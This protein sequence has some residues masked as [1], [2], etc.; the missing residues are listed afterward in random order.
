MR[1]LAYR[2][3]LPVL[4]LGSLLGNQTWYPGFPRAGLALFYVSLVLATYVLLRVFGRQAWPYALLGVIVLSRIASA[5]E[6]PGARF[7]Y[8]ASMNALFVVYG[9]LLAADAP[10]MLQRQ[11]RIFV[12]ASVPLLALQLMG[13]AEWLH[14]FNTLYSVSDAYGN[15]YRP[16]IR[17]LPTLFMTHEELMSTARSDYYEFFAWQVRPSG[18]AHSSAMLG[19]LILGAA[20]LHFGRMSA[21]RVTWHDAIFVSA[22]VLCCSKLA[23]LGFVL[24]M[25]WSYVRFDPVMRPRIGG[26][27]AMF[28][29]S[30]LV[31]GAMFPAVFDH[32][33]GAGA[34]E[35]S[36]LL[37]AVDAFLRI[38]PD[39][40]L[41]MPAVVDVIRAYD[42][43]FDYRGGDAG[44]L[45]GI[46]TLVFAFPLI[47]IGALAGLPWII[48]GLRFCGTVYPATARTAELMMIVAFVIPIAT[49]IFVSQFFALFIGLAL[50]PLASS[51][52]PALR[53]RLLRSAVRAANGK[54]AA[55]PALPVPA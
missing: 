13:A 35:V 43:T 34:F 23:L 21:R 25:L 12:L 9:V 49:P 50:M 10:E 30:L 7:V 20:A 51:L 48:R 40:A 14:A 42:T 44:D 55:T 15:V 1:L 24:L 17:M 27:A 36:F 38:A 41:Q 53:R 37:R 26:I 3:T 45:S 32:N 33:L 19:I 31:Y 54:R 8:L 46:A 22:V 4:W 6:L 47:A 2:I 39:L 29:A 11:A 16:A 52:S 5:G 18:L 28:V